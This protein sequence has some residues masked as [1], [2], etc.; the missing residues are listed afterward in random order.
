MEEVMQ[1]A[2]EL[3]NDNDECAIAVVLSATNFMSK[4]PTIEA[5]LM[6]RNTMTRLLKCHSIPG[7]EH[8]VDEPAGDDLWDYVSGMIHGFGAVPL[9]WETYVREKSLLCKS[10][11]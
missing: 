8:F 4:P 5:A 3:L 1:R 9:A 6:Y 10:I 2:I 7:T 11:C